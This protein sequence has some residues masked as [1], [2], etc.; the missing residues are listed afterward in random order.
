MLDTRQLIRL[1]FD[2]LYGRGDLV[3][4]RGVGD[5]RRDHISGQRQVGRLQLERLIVGLRIER[6]DLPVRAAPDIERVG[7]ADRGVEELVE[8]ALLARDRARPGHLRKQGAL[9]G[10]RGLPGGA[11]GEFGGLNISM[12]ASGFFNECCELARVK[13]PPPIA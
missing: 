1:G 10:D 12:V 9:L 4:Q 3:P 11:Q 13:V 7:D 6:L 8:R 2:D 5:R